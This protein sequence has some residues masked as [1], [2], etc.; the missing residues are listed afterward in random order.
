MALRIVLLVALL[1]LVGCNPPKR[2]EKKKRT[3]PPKVTVKLPPVQ[4]LKVPEYQKYYA[5]QSLTVQHLMR[6]VA[7]LFRKEDTVVAVTGVIN[8][9][10]RC[11]KKDDNRCTT[12]PHFYLVDKPGDQRWRLLVVDIP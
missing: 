7:T 10:K 3:K 5:D 12:I 9:L 4:D 2:Q 11:E 1:A 6:S 8:G